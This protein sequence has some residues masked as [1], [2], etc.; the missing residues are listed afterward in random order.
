[1]FAFGFIWVCFWAFL[2]GLWFCDFLRRF[3]LIFAYRFGLFMVD[4]VGL[5]CDFRG[6]FAYFM[7]FGR[8]LVGVVLLGVELVDH[9][10]DIKQIVEGLPSAL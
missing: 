6:R 8:I 3:L 9:C 10:L 1:M 4:G 5:N 7:S 2:G